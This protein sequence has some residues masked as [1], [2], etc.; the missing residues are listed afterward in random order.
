MLAAVRSGAPRPTVNARAMFMVHSAMYDAWAAYDQAASPTVLDAGVRR[1]VKEQTEANKQAAAS[2]AAYHTLIALFPRYEE[3][4]RAFSQMMRNLGYKLVTKAD[5]TTPAGIGFLAAQEVLRARQSDGANAVNNYVDIISAVYPQ[6]YE[7][8]NAADPASGRTPGQP[9]FEPNHWQPL[10]VPSGGVV[11]A[12]GNPTIDVRNSASY[13]DQKYLTPHWGTVRPFALASGDQFRPPAPPLAGSSKP[14]TDALGRTMTNDQA[15]KA[16]FTQVLNF[17]AHLT[18]E[19]KCIAEYW[20]DGPRS[21]TPPGHWNTLAHGISYRDR[22]TLDQDVK[23]YFVLNGALFDA[24]IAAWDAKRAYDFVRP[25]SALP[26]LYAG[27]QIEA[28]AGPD[29]GT[30][31]IPADQWKP[32]QDVT[33]VTPAFPEYVSGH[34]TFSA[35]AAE[36]LTLFTGSNRFYDGKTILSDDLNRDGVPDRLGEHIMPVNSNRFEDG[37]AEVVVLRWATF[38]EA[39]DEAGISRLYGGIHIQDSDR[40]GRQLGQQIG[41]QAFDLAEQLWLGQ[42]DA[43]NR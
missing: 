41:H 16:Q 11:D 14:Y 1:P 33:F 36:I 29:L 27:Q 2:Q 31:T 22:H 9:A 35:A 28:W 3:D 39:A 26:H 25:A 43:V 12:Q 19:M 42:G 17:N 34:S 23:L 21:E 5:P 20:A 30:Q 18:D 8:V 37:P 32:Y 24:S 13:V 15:Y 40:Y 38:Q 4:T 7:P 10:R 6:R